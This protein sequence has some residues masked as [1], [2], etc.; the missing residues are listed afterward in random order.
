MSL[1][2]L[3]VILSRT[4]E[5]GTND[6]TVLGTMYELRRQDNKNTLSINTKF[7]MNSLRKEWPM[8]AMIYVGKTSMTYECIKEEGIRFCGDYGLTASNSNYQQTSR[9]SCHHK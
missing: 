6:N 5:L 8:F 3:E 1:L 7:G 4:R 2:D 9:L